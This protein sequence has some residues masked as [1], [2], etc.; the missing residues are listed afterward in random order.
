V[1]VDTMGREV[2][3]APVMHRQDARVTIKL[4]Q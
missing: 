4:Q 2:D 1:G 3:D